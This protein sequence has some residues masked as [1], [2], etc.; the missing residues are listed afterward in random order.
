[1]GAESALDPVL[2]AVLALQGAPAEPA[3]SGHER[4]DEATA[5]ALVDELL[6]ALLDESLSSFSGRR[7]CAPTPADPS[8]LAALLGITLVP[9]RPVA[10]GT[11]ASELGAHVW[12]RPL[13]PVQELA[14]SLSPPLK[15]EAS[16]PDFLQVSPPQSLP[17]PAALHQLPVADRLGGELLV[18]LPRSQ[19]EPVVARPLFAGGEL[20]VGQPP[21][22]ASR[23]AAALA[24]EPPQL[25]APSVDAR[26]AEP[27]QL[28]TPSVDVRAAEP[29]QLPAP[30]LDAW[31]A[32]PP[33]L[34]AA[35]HEV[36]A[37]APPQLP[38]ASHEVPAAAPP[39]VPAVPPQLPALS[40]AELP[41]LPAPTAQLRT[42]RR[43]EAANADEVTAWLLDELL[44]DE[45][46]LQMPDLQ[47]TLLG[48]QRSLSAAAAMGGQPPTAAGAGVPP[49]AEAS[50]SPEAAGLDLEDRIAD[51]ILSTLVAQLV[52]EVQRVLR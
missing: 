28:P 18:D 12:A 44:S 2:L 37:A 23:A 20:E 45:L 15:E 16:L 38:A 26:A 21:A 42:S 30:S 29:S 32:E 14:L 4:V 36:P 47:G 7:A 13:S 46:R 34:A 40:A 9:H 17:P 51:A 43:A 19:W 24:P 49:V 8:T 27:P 35:S 10:A 1:M 50:G 39:Q 31:A 3:S 5:D 48:Q 52:P 11:G 6:D 22:A 25:P 41:Q 33:Q